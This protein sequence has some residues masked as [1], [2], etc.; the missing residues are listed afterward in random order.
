LDSGTQTGQANWLQATSHPHDGPYSLNQD[1]VGPASISAA[2]L[3]SPEPDTIAA[4]TLGASFAIG[5]AY[6]RRIKSRSEADPE[7]CPATSGT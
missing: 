2:A 4:A 5:M 3:P 6:R 1:L 7:E